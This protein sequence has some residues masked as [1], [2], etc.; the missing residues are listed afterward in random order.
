MSLGIHMPARSV[1]IQDLRKRSELGFRTLKVSELTQM[2]GRA[3]RRGIDTEGKCIIGTDGR[4]S[5]QDALGLIRGTPEPIESR[6]RI[7]YSSAALLVRIYPE[8]VV[9]RQTIE[10]S[11]GQFQARKRVRR[12]EAEWEKRLRKLSRREGLA[13]T[14]CELKDFVAYQANRMRMAA[15]NLAARRGEGRRRGRRRPA[16]SPWDAVLGSDGGSEGVPVRDPTDFACHACPERRRLEQRFERSRRLKVALQ[17]GMAVLGRVHEPYWHQF[18]RVAR[19]LHHFGYLEAGQL[20]VEGRLVA[21]LRH[22]NELL[23]ARVLFAGILD[24]LSPAELVALLSCLIEEPREAEPLY[25]RNFLQSHPSLQKRVRRMQDRAE[26]LLQVQHTY[27][28][29]LP[30][31]M[32]IGYLVPTYRWASGEGDWL[33]L[34]QDTYGGHEGDLIRAFRRLIDLCRQLAENLETGSAMQE[35]LWQAVSLLDRD[36]ILESALL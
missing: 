2:A 24:D 35:K 19:V 30:I 29:S 33:R 17:E 13:P 9:I 11:F 36:I 14:C 7:G 26:E 31:A 22:E 12:L 4:E 10:R 34:V 6:F 5:L 3:G 20:S 28:I 16:R 15:G 27:Q 23:V 1:V 25:A 32:H 18:L 21:A 8:P